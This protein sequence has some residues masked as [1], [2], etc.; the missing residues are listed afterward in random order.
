MIV[1]SWE[2]KGRTL[3]AAYME[4]LGRVDSMFCVGKLG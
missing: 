4:A 2:G 3:K 1:E